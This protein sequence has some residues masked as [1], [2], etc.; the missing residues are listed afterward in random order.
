METFTLSG[1]TQGH[2]AHP[3]PIAQKDDLD[4]ILRKIPHFIVFTDIQYKKP[5]ISG[6]PIYLGWSN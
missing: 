4:G 1:V 2:L 6:Y 5:T 3:T